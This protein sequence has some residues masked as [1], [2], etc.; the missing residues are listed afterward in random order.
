M[1]KFL[2]RV[3]KFLIQ[4]S[5]PFDSRYTQDGFNL[6]SVQVCSLELFIKASQALIWLAFFNH[7]NLAI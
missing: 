3:F 4:V 6:I 2:I 1:L 7:P 5:A